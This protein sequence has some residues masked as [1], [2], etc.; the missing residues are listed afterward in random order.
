MHGLMT[1]AYRDEAGGPAVCSMPRL[2]SMTC[3]PISM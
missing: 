2:R 1:T 3:S